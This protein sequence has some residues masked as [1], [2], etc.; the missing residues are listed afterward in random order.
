MP[1][2]FSS[3]TQT[4]PGS[5][6][7]TEENLPSQ[8]GKVF[9]VTGGNSGLG[10]ELAKILYSK[11]ATVYIAGRSQAKTSTAIQTIQT[12]YPSSSGKLH[13]LHLDLDDL[14]SVKASAAAFAAQESHL[15]VLWNNAGIS[16]VPNGS[17]TKQGIEQHMGTNCVAPLLFSQLLLPQL[18]S[19]AAEAPKASVR[20]VWTSSFL[21]DT[22]APP[23][24]LVV[25]ELSA[26]LNDPVRNYAAS[27][28][29]NWMLAAEWARRFGDDGIL[30]LT[31]NPGSLSTNIWRHTSRLLRFLVSPLLYEPKFGAY[32]EAWAGLSPDVTM[33]DAGKYAIPWGRWHLSPRE[34]VLD[35]IKSKELGGTGAAAAFWD[36]CEEQTAQYVKPRHSPQ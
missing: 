20:I 16:T 5:P 3:W 11:E 15:H 24:G 31:Q 18:R 4:F 1:S 35:A 33:E 12:S 7:F 6:T 25:A 17:K 10:F 30:S 34:D 8:T 2:L 32:T 36:W 22:S 13:F 27:K 29:G 23:G 28:A 19:A 14:E 26:P 9:I 21:V